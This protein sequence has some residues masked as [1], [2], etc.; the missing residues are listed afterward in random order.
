MY[1]NIFKV[2]NFTIK[3]MYGMTVIYMKLWI[4]IKH[5]MVSMKNKPIIFNYVY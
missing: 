1:Y 3:L 2:K 4:Q 5:L